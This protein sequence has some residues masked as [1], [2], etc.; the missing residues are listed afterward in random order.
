MGSVASMPVGDT[1]ADIEELTSNSL[2][3]QNMFYFKGRQRR[4][5][6]EDVELHSLI[7]TLIL[8]LLATPKK[9][10]LDSRYSEQYPLQS[11][12]RNIPFLL[13]LHLNHSAN[14]KV[15]PV[16]TQHVEKISHIGGFRLLKLLCQTAMHRW[17]YTN[18]IRA[19]SGQF[20][21][22]SLC[23]VQ[24]SDEIERVAIKQINKQNSFRI[25][26]SFSKSSAK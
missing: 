20:G 1:P 8:A 10:L 15:L 26:V 21:Q 5:I 14:A 2:V 6:Y 13:S 3:H 11:H 22:V 17:M 4:R 24:L 16:L 18:W 12:K 9:G 19:G 7:L 23:T 25:A